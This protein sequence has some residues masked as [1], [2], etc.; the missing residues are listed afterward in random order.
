[1]LPPEVLIL[2]ALL[3]WGGLLFLVV[4]ALWRIGSRR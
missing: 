4:R 2:L 3:V 1:M